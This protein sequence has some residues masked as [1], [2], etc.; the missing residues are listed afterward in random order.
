MPRLV[1]ALRSRIDYLLFKARQW[2]QKRQ[3]KRDDDNLSALVNHAAAGHHSRHR[4]PAY[5]LS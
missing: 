4:P 5:R 2:R 1:D 3:A